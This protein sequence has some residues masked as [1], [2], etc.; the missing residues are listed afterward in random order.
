MAV[1]SLFLIT[2]GVLCLVWPYR[3]QEYAL[4]QRGMRLNPFGGF[5]RGRGYIWN[6]R[7]CGSIA[8]AMAIVLLVALFGR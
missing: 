2:L 3:V 5:M 8:I 4:K 6:L 1:T 7:I